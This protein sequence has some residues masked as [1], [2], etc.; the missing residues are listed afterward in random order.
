[1]TMPIELKV[2]LTFLLVFVACYVVSPMKDDGSWLYKFIAVAG[3]T[4]LVGFFAAVLWLVW[5]S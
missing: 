5:M 4:S 1:M 3:A 2:A